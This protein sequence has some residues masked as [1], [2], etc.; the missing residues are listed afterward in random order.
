MPFLSALIVSH[1]V[2]HFIHPACIFELAT[3]SAAAQFSIQAIITTTL[4]L[5]FLLDISQISS[6]K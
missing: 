6:L 2:I 1:L 3:Y 4:L 5:A